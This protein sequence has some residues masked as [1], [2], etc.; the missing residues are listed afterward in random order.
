MTITIKVIK[1]LRNEKGLGLIEAHQVLLKQDFLKKVEEADSV[2][3]LRI[4]LI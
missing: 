4:Q 1:K 3:K 2:K